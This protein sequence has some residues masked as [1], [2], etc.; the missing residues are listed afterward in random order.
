MRQCCD[1]R[2]KYSYVLVNW[3]ELERTTLHE[4]DSPTYK[5]WSQI[6]KRMSQFVRRYKKCDSY[7]ADESSV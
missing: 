7:I 4:V 2:E 3:M 1:G 6:E 5:E